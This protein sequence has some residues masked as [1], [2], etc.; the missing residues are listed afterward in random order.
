MLHLS[1]MYDNGWFFFTSHS[2]IAFHIGTVAL[3]LWIGNFRSENLEELCLT[4]NRLEAW[5]SRFRWVLFGT[6]TSE[7]VW[8]N[9]TIAAIQAKYGP[10]GNIF[11]IL[12]FNLFLCW[13]CWI[14]LKGTA[15]INLCTVE[16]GRGAK[17]CRAAW[18]MKHVWVWA[19]KY[20][21]YSI[22]I[23]HSQ[24]SNI[25]IHIL[26]L[27]K[28]E[29]PAYPPFGALP[30]IGAKWDDTGIPHITGL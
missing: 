7:M 6:D 18:C 11:G 4:N 24:R 19:L 17:I 13:I 26:W 23:A 27:S 9:Q 8:R 16:V 14:V 15:C 1:H 28:G 2:F 30:I 20:S 29:T 3:G 22:L 10:I 25:S 5:L 21:T 12:I